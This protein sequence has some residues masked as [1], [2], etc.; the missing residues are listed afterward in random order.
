MYW[1]VSKKG[2]V[3]FVRSN[4]TL[5]SWYMSVFWRCK[6]RK[7]LYNT[8]VLKLVLCF[9]INLLLKILIYWIVS[10][11]GSV[12]FVRSNC[13]LKSWYMSVFWR[14]K[15]RKKLYNT[16]A[17]KFVLCFLLICFCLLKILMYWIVSKKGS[18]SFV[19]SNCTLKSWYA[20]LFWNWKSM[21]DV[22]QYISFVNLLKNKN[23]VSTLC[24]DL[25]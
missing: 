2:S 4:C 12:S 11:K 9:F 17:L 16:L 15:I 5:K 3:S 6:I 21:K 1:I 19:R 14:C 22:V 10:K 24:F 18:V 25:C 7:K 23:F 20:S 13:T 8:L